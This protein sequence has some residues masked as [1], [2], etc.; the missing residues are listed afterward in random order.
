MMQ[1]SKHDDYVYIDIAAI[2]FL[3]MPTVQ[4][5]TIQFLT[6]KKGS[7]GFISVT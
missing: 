5:S 7:Q 6:S 1:L 2:K 3:S 4:G